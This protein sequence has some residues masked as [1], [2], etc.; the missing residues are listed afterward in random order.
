MPSTRNGTWHDRHR[1]GGH[2]EDHG[3]VGAQTCVLHSHLD[4][5]GAFLG[6]GEVAKDA[7]TV[8]EQ[9]ADGI[10]AEDHAEGEEEE[11]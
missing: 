8:A 3:E 1:V 6:D 10:V 11:Q 9:V 7:D 4:G 2:E 5:E